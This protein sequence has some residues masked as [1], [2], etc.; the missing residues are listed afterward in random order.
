LYF[1]N[2]FAGFGRLLKCMFEAMLAVA[3]V[4]AIGVWILNALANGG[5]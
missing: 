4:A 5:Y 1:S 2:R 3:I